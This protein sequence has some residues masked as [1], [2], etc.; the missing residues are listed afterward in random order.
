MAIDSF[1]RVF[2]VVVF[3]YLGYGIYGVLGG[4]AA[5]SLIGI[6]YATTSFQP[7]RTNESISYGQILD[8]SFPVIIYSVFFHLTSSLDLFFI[9]SSTIPGEYVG[10]Y[11][12]ARVLSTIFAIVSVSFSSTLLPSISHSFSR[13][14][15]KTT[16]AYIQTSLRYLFIVFIPIAVIIS[17]YS[18]AVLGLLFT[19]EY[20]N[21]G[22]A[23]SILIWGWFFLQIFFVL[24]AM[25]NASGRSKLPAQ[26]AGISVLIS[27]ISNYYLVSNYGIEGGAIATFIAGMVSVLGGFYFVHKIFKVSVDLNSTLK[28]GAGSLMLFV[29][30]ILVDAE[31]VFLLGWIL[32]LLA[33][34]LVF[35][36]LIKVIN[37]E[38]IRLMRELYQSFVSANLTAQP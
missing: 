37:N 23:L 3:V 38:D 12:S 6:I 32:I 18:K 16:R 24:S 7:R 30:S 10:F 21:A 8:F 1:P 11:T 17:V 2:F 15:M 29:I 25:I 27:F 22:D 19:P 33:I 9:K 36:F 31:G 13:G 28:L 34:Y 5:A 20:A 4:Y 14:D 26:L 35:L